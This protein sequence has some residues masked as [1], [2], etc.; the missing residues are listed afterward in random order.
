MSSKCR[1]IVQYH[2]FRTGSLPRIQAHTS[3]RIS[4]PW[5]NPRVFICRK[6]ISS[7]PSFPAQRL[8]QHNYGLCS[9]ELAVAMFYRS[10]NFTCIFWTFR[11]WVSS[12]EIHKK[13]QM[14]TF[15]DPNLRTKLF[16][17]FYV[18]YKQLA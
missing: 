3:F 4:Q 5:I 14:L 16:R 9:V 15:W 13:V 12:Q 7:L 1:F 18:D 2:A 10:V 8:Q 11:F 6:R 17:T